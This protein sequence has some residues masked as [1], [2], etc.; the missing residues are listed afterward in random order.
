MK[1]L[2]YDIEIKRAI[3]NRGEAKIEGIEYC[4][5]WG[6]HAN[7][8]ISVIGAYDYG[9]DRYRVFC[10]DNKEEFFEAAEAAEVLITFNGIGFDDPVIT[11]CWKEDWEPKAHKFD[12]MAEMRKASG[13]RP[14]LDGTCQVNFG[15]AKS[16]SGA[17]APILW[18][19]GKIGEVIDYCMN[20]IKM[21][22]LAF[23]LIVKTGSII[24]PKSNKS[25]S[26]KTKIG[27]GK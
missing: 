15:V 20:D 2:I 26:I 19:R 5:G 27:G 3:P 16:N 14:S 8:G 22:K 17:L 18:Q 10:D 6:D 21:T 9:T 7:M 12:I 4:E 11:A 24:C 1:A 25:I 13:L 23:D